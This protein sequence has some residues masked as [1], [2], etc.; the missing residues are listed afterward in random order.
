MKEEPN[1]IDFL[2]RAAES[3][4]RLEAV[5]RENLVLKREVEE[6]RSFQPVREEA[7]PVETALP[8]SVVELRSSLRVV[9]QS[10]LWTLISVPTPVFVRFFEETQP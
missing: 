4:L 7:A 10:G 3:E 9:R 5:Q 1:L 8:A 2:S 6:L